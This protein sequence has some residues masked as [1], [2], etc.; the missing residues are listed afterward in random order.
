MPRQYNFIYEKLVEDENDIVGNIAYSLYKSDKIKFIEDFKLKHSGNEPTEQDLKPFHDISC[1]PPTIQRYRMQAVMILQ[2]FL[3]ST[4]STTTKQIESD[5]VNNHKNM[6]KEIMVEFKPKS[7]GY[8]V[9]QSV[10]GAFVFMILICGLLFC[11]S[12]SDTKYSFT[13]GG[14]GNAT[15]KKEKDK[16]ESITTPTIICDSIK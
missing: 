11:L 8:G 1:I 7:F 4:L 5:C 14:N 12:L 16:E 6:L 15:L 10:V 13:F 2:V 9:K 3:E